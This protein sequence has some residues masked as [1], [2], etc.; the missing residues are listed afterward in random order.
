MRCCGRR[1]FKTTQ[2]WPGTLDARL[3]TH[4]MRP[5]TSST[6]CSTLSDGFPTAHFMGKVS[7]DMFLS[8][9]A[10]GF[11]VKAEGILN[12]RSCGVRA[13]LRAPSAVS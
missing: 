7:L 9:S 1:G 5:V 8:L 10:V 4:G 13:L 11:S 2:P 12:L 6:S 3:C